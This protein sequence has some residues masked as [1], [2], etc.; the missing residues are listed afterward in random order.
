MLII[1]LLNQDLINI[2]DGLKQSYNANPIGTKSAMFLIG[3]IVTLVYKVETIDKKKEK[4]NV[5]KQ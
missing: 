1:D 2:M 4:R 5:V 3:F